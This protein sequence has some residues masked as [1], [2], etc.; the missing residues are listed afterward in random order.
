MELVLYY[1]KES[2]S[3]LI[4][5]LI[6]VFVLGIFAYMTM[7]NFRQDSKLKVGFYGLFLG[8]KNVDIVKL[9][10]VIIRIF[11]VFYSV[12]ITAREKVFICLIMIGLLSLLYII[13]S[14]KKIV[15]EIVSTLMEIVMIYF[16][17]IINSYMVDIEYAP[18][19]L[20]IKVC[21]IVFTILLST[22]FLL[23]NIGDVVDY[24]WNKEFAKSRKELKDEK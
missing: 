15:Y 4:S 20:M 13:L 5:F 24:R 22:Y 2:A 12:M 14:P 11:L 8:L 18:E 1:I 19:I 10:I 21:L 7:R 9:S 17:Y 3:L 6:L 16:V 23:R